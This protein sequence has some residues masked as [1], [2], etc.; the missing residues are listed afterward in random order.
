MLR[1]RVKWWYSKIEAILFRGEEM[2]VLFGNVAVATES[3]RL[4]SGIGAKPH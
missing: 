2:D 1:N 4:L 3:S